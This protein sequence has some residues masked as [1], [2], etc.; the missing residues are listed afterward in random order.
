MIKRL[1][2]SSIILICIIF[3]GCRDGSVSDTGISVESATENQEAYYEEAREALNVVVRALENKD[4]ELIKS[5]LADKTIQETPNLDSE[6]QYIFDMYKCE[7]VQSSEYKI[8]CTEINLFGEKCS[9][10]N[11]CFDLSSDEQK[12]T[13]DALYIPGNDGLLTSSGFFSIVLADY[14]RKWNNYVTAR[15][16]YDFICGVFSSDLNTIDYNE[17]KIGDFYEEVGLEQCQV[18]VKF[19]LNKVG[20]EKILEFQVM[21]VTDW[22]GVNY[23]V[24]DKINNKYYVCVDEIGFV[25]KVCENDENGKVLYDSFLFNHS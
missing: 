15:P 23:I 11:I 20:I 13:L 5:V 25:Y 8:S 3:F 12:Y 10:I 2:L 9:A 14:D 4:A 6:I 18:A 22:G 19:E 7:N 16:Y 24:L 21:E 17:D 1:L